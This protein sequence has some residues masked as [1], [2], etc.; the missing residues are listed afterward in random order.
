MFIGVLI[1]NFAV[2][3]TVLVYFSLK[4]WL[5]KIQQRC[6]GKKSKK[7][8]TIEEELYKSVLSLNSDQQ[9]EGF[10]ISA[11]AYGQGMWAVAMSKGTDFTTQSFKNSVGL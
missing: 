2:N 10:R 6:Q 9:L 8:F 3:L 11:K 5:H 1:L 7:F 4:A